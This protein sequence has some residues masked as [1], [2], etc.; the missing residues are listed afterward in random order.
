MGYG[1][2]FRVSAEGSNVGGCWVVEGDVGGA[3]GGFND[4]AGEGFG[5]IGWAGVEQRTLV[6]AG[7]FEGVDE[8][9]SALEVD[10]SRGDGLEEHGGG[11]LHGLGVFERRKE[12][13]ILAG[14]GAL[15]VAEFVF[16][17]ALEA[18]LLPV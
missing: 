10:L 8:K 5:L 13:F 2:G 14:I 18:E 6:D 15:D 11:E 9:A 17:G 12:D 3:V 4:V 1:I 16:L 7:D